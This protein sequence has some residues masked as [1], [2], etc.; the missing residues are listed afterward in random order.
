MQWSKKGCHRCLIRGLS[1]QYTYPVYR[2]R[3][4]RRKPGSTK[5]PNSSLSNAATLTNAMP[6]SASDVLSRTPRPQISL[7]PGSP[8][9][10]GGMGSKLCDCTSSMLSLL[11]ESEIEGDWLSLRTIDHFLR[12]NKHRLARCYRVLECQACSSKFE[13]DNVGHHDL[14][15]NGVST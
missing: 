11:E 8:S 2:K 13:F 14:P 1:C 9:M 4:K 3:R 6:Q 15:N 12:L 10:E 7:A 5:T